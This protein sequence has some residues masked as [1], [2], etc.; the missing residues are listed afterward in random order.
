MELQPTGSGCETGAAHQG[1][2]H[3]SRRDGQDAAA[4][5]RR[6]RTQSKPL[7]SVGEPDLWAPRIGN[8]QLFEGPGPVLIKPE[9]DPL[10]RSEQAH[11]Q[12]ARSAR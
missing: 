6:K 8:F 9:D 10:C 12:R 4:G 11:G 3:R 1:S 7:E 2:Q 5:E